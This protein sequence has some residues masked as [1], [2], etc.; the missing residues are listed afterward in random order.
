MS[1]NP[2]FETEVEQA[3][4]ELQR[5][6][7]ILYPTDT[8]W[9]LGCDATDE[10][11]IRKIYRIKNREDTKSLI[12]LL[13]ETR[14]LL[15]YV[16]AP[17]PAVFDFIEQA[18]RPTTIVFQNAI[19]LPES[20]IAADG[21][22]AIRIIQDPFCRHLIKRL[23][24]P[25]VSTSANCSGEPAPQLFSD[26]SDAIRQ[27]VDHVVGWRQDDTRPGQPS[28]IIKWNSD[29]TTTVLRP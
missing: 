12:I 4:A 24:K 5:G 16:A 20:L 8:I 23:R 3:L 21:S 10:T 1:M 11:A 29:G 9:G 13:A 25:L 7:V 19:C 6:G 28:Q 17:D 14:D 26:V 22:I 27:E 2:F 15:Q 18:Q